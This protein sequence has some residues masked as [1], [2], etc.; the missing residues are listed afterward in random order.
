[1]PPR[2]GIS[3]FAKPAFSIA[4]ILL[5][6]A[7]SLASKTHKSPTYDETVHLFAGYSYLKWGDYRVNPEH[8]PLIKML[9]AA[10]LLALNLNTS[11]IT[12][13]QRY[14]VQLD[15][16]YGWVLAH[17]FVF[18]DNDAETLFFYARIVMVFLAVALALCVGC[19]ARELYGIEAALIALFMVCFDPNI[20][21]HSS[22]V[23]TDVP[24]A[25]VF[26]S[27]T[28]FLWRSL[29]Q[30][31]WFNLT[32]TALLFAAAAVTKFSF[33]T[34]IP[35]WLVLGA[36]TI[37]SSKPLYSPITIPQE[38]TGRLRKAA[39]VGTILI[40][41]V[42][43]GYLAIWSAYQFRFEAIPYQ[44]G[45]LPMADLSS[46]NSWLGW[47][48]QL[49]RDY[50]VLP[51]ALVYGLSDAYLRME[52]TSYLFG[53]IS[54]NGFWLYFPAAFLVKTP[55]PILIAIVIATIYTIVHR[56][57]GSDA[58]FLLGP[59]LIFFLVAVWSRLNVGWRHIIP[60]YPFL[61]VWLGG[62]LSAMWRS[63]R[64]STRTA[65]II[66]GVWLCGSTLWT[67]PNYLAYF[68]ELVGGSSKGHLYLVD[69][70]LDWGQDLKA[71][72]EWMA[73]N[74]VDKIQLA[75]FGTADPA[76]YKIG[77][78]YL[79]GSVYHTEPRLDN[80]ADSPRYV[81]ISETFLAGLYLDSPERY[82]DFRNRD[83]VALINYSIRVYKISGDDKT[84]GPDAQ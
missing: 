55:A 27:A 50:Y 37:F 9:A 82:A 66:L 57:K 41:S 53:V 12:P 36:V 64:R 3:R 81:A 25:L 58:W 14:I 48:L 10:P 51:E 54:Q 32:A 77:A 8:P 26:F 56:R 83:P 62:S 17:R 67:Y 11:G 28:F 5:F 40:L 70:S 42:L 63:G 46:D 80:V 68:N 15:K 29:Q 18:G 22:I 61:F 65:L 76:Y 1:M 49:C 43:L 44:R 47:L 4:L 31:T 74:H 23:Q 19:W 35:I 52:R 24:F 84:Q 39:L 16:N 2:M 45:D 38:I 20:I 73:R 69:S 13:R 6:V 30:L 34:I 59:V 21:A 71:L 7:L 75:Y 33:V 79:P 72:K 60:I 78:V